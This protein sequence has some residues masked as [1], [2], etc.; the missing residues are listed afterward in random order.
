MKR[1]IQFGNVLVPVIAPRLNTVQE[2]KI[3]RGLSFP[4]FNKQ[5]PLTQSFFFMI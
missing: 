2:W 1:E 5:K 4:L 3:T